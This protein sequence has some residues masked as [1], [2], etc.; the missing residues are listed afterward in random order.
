MRMSGQQISF[1]KGIRYSFRMGPHIFTGT[2]LR[3]ETSDSTGDQRT[4]AVFRGKDGSEYGFPDDYLEG[5][6]LIYSEDPEWE[7]RY[8]YRDPKWFIEVPEEF[9]PYMEM[10]ELEDFLFTHLIIEEN[11][12][13]SPVGEDPYGPTENLFSSPE[14]PFLR[15]WNES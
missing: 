9:E 4:I 12:G 1:K 14:D 2:Y 6:V 8:Q 13:E 11:N 10:E 3:E 7:Q 5:A 15:K